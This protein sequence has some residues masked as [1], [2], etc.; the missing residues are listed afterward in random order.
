M[1]SVSA[2]LILQ[3]ILFFLFLIFVRYDENFNMGEYPLFQ[4]IHVM[5]FIG[6]GFLMACLRRYAFSAIGFNFLIGAVMLQWSII[7]RGIY[8]LDGSY[9]ILINLQSLFNADITTCSVLISMGV[10]LGTTTHV[11]LLIMGMMEVIFFSLNNYISLNLLRACDT[12]GSVVLHAFGS[13]FGLAVSFVVGRGRVMDCHNKC[14]RYNS[15]IFAMIGTIFLWLYWPSFSGIS[16]PSDLKHRAIINTYLALASCCVTTFAFSSWFNGN[17]KLEMVHIQNATLA[18]GVAIGS[19]ASLLVQPYGAILIGILSAI[20]SMVG[21]KKVTPW[22]ETKWKINDT[23]GVNNLH[24]IPGILGGL[25]GTFFASLATEEN[26]GLALYELYP[27]RWA[28]EIHNS[29]TRKN[30]DEAYRRDAYIQA[31]FQFLSILITIAISTVSGYITGLLINLERFQLSPCQ[32][33]MDYPF[34]QINYESPLLKSPS[35][36]RVEPKAH[37]QLQQF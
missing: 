19:S 4:D 33:F 16:L 27:A 32:F 24:G 1:P 30:S 15:D 9:K 8:K 17:Q 3:L 29:T 22:L 7:C 2:V 36:I 31:G 21:F 5:V 18:G 34:W 10:V 11:Q 25:I 13:F 20:I 6:F 23:C 28:D 37:S 12:G 14:S 35:R 26:Y